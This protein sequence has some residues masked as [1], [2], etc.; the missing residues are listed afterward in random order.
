MLASEIL[1]ATLPQD[2]DIRDTLL[3]ELRKRFGE[4]IVVLGGDVFVLPES[5]NWNDIEIG[6]ESAQILAGAGLRVGNGKVSPLS[7]QAQ[8]NGFLA[9]FWRIRRER[10]AARAEW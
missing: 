10:R 3:S 9:R 7:V 4:R 5:E 6:E 2:A 1:S 8:K